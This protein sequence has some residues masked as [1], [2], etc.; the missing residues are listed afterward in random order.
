MSSSPRPAT[1]ASTPL[2]SSS[3]MLN[4]QPTARVRRRARTYTAEVK[5]ALIAVWRASNQL[6]SKR[7]VPFLAELV[8]VLERHRHLSLSDE[9]RTTLLGISP[10]TTDRL[11]GEFR[12]PGRRRRYGSTR[13]GSLLKHQVPVRTFADWD[14]LAPGFVEADLSRSLRHDGT[15]GVSQQPCAD[16]RFDRLDRMLSVALSWTEQLSSQHSVKRVS[17][18]R[19][20]S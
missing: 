8:P 4:K 17:C 7:L 5:D 10:A 18:C 6:C 20:R 15:R 14:D 2:R 11:L 12:R 9:T 19:S 16:R 3:S 13:P 1:I